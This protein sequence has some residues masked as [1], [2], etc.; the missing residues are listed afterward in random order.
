MRKRQCFKKL[1]SQTFAV[2]ETVVK[3]NCYEKYAVSYPNIALKIL[4]GH[5]FSRY[6]LICVGAAAGVA[7]AFSSPI[8][9]LTFAMEEM[10]SHWSK[11]LTWQAFV[12]CILARST[13]ELFRSF[14]DAAESVE[15]HGGSYLLYLSESALFD[16]RSIFKYL[17]VIRYKL[18][19]IK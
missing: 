15:E 4:M 3:G 14:M 2:T 16:V 12:C 7:A 17:S 6:S 18:I 19:W 10:S 1:A 11:T 5:I 13:A 9:G 8:A